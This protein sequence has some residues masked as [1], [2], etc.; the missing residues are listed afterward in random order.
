MVASSIDPDARKMMRA[1]RF[2]AALP[3]AERTIVGATVC[4]PAHAFLASL[5]LKLGRMADAVALV[6]RSMELADGSADAYDGLAHV[7]TEIGEHEIAHNLYLRATQREPEVPRHWHNLASSER[8][9]GRL[10]EAEQ[11]CNRA[12]ALDAKQ[13]PSLLL[14]SELLRQTDE[15]NHVADLQARLAGGKLDVTGQVYVG[16]A[17]G[18][19]FDDLDRIN[20]AFRC[21]SYAAKLRRSQ[22]RY[23]IADDERQMQRISALFRDDTASALAIQHP[24]PHVFVIGLPRTGTTLVERIITGLPGVRSNGETD[25]FSQALSLSLAAGPGDAL[26]RAMNADPAA[27]ASHYGRLARVLPGD[28]A[29]VEKL[30]TNY[31]YVGF[32]RRALPNARIIALR[33]SPLDSCFAMFRSLFGAAYP[34]SY[35]FDELARYY[36]AYERLMAHW[37]T[38]YGDTLHF[39]SYEELVKQPHVVGAAAA[40]YCGLQ[41]NSRA[42]D[43][44]NNR[45]VSLTASASQVRMPIYGSSS[46]RWRSYEAHLGPLISALR[47]QGVSTSRL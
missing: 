2:A 20:E 33:R 36:A 19:E 45:S 41:W 29:V 44:Q 15:S 4:T 31:L 26:R 5:Y 25:N 37:S 28:V 30:P 22:L 3:L 17:L 7:A 1:G 46:G 14:R 16:Y 43:I 40:R 27:V 23:D 21:F 10:K 42:V 35:D 12:I 13:Y 47:A 18:K 11:A 32:I 8:S 9:F 24:S 6:V 39:V 34:F 38:L